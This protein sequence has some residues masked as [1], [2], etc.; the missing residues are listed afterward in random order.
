M[1]DRFDKEW[2][3]VAAVWLDEDDYDEFRCKCT[4]TSKE[5]KY[6]KRLTLSAD[7]IVADEYGRYSVARQELHEVHAV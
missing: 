4:C 5:L 1:F 7:T 2:D 6:L 3:F